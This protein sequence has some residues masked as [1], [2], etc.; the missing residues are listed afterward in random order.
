MKTLAGIE[1]S[2]AFG[3]ALPDGTIWTITTKQGEA[4]QA[5]GRTAF[6]ACAFL[7]LSLGQVAHIQPA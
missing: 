1:E 3:P 7:G 4:R 5:I 6:E 2:K